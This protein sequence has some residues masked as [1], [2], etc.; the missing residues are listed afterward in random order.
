MDGGIGPANLADVLAAGGD[1]VVAGSA[2]FKS[3][4]GAIG[5]LKEL[6]ELDGRSTG[7]LE[8]S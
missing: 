2:V 6:R 3:E 8:Q 7:V 1:I 4:L 5:A